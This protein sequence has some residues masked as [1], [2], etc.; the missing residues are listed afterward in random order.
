M[1]HHNNEW[2]LRMVFNSAVT[3]RKEEENVQTY[4]RDQ[5]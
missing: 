4:L 2:A 3:E 1:K 5:H